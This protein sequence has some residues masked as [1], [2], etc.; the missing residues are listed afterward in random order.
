MQKLN[1]IDKIKASIKN[2]RNKF[3]NHLKTIKI[4]VVSIHPLLDAVKDGEF[5]PQRMTPK[6]RKAFKEKLV[7]NKKLFQEIFQLK[8]KNLSYDETKNIMTLNF[9]TQI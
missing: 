4:I 7:R 8:I 3:E 9:K 5:V 1:K 2:F 6:V